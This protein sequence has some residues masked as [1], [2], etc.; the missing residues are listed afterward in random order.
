MGS[1]SF[2]PHA[3]PQ[4][5]LSWKPA[6][7]VSENR[8]TYTNVRDIHASG[9]RYA[10]SSDEELVLLAQESDAS[11]FGELVRRHF[12]VC[13]SRAFLILR[14]RCDAEDE[15]QNA[16]LKAFESLHQF[17]FRGTFAAWLCRIV[18]NQC[19]MLIRDRNQASLLSVDAQT[20]SSAKLEV[21]NQRPD[22]EEDLG[23]RQVDRLLHDEIAHIPPLMRNV[24][25]LR[26]VEGRPMPE[27]AS[28][29]GLSVPAAK[30]RLMRARRELRSRLKRHCGASGLRTLSRKT[31]HAKAEYTYVS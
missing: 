4:E 2:N 13:L 31:A 8:K 24:V 25:V 23:S 14:N 10:S 19:L 7:P 27:V 22:Q 5:V 21:V 17:R 29:L 18:Q 6:L 1:T 3:Q 12:S 11:A 26:D 20:K 30:S 28:I 15:V 9:A 16:F